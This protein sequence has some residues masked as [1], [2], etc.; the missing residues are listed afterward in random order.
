MATYKGIKG[1][2]VQSL[3]TDPVTAGTSWSSGGNLNMARA[4]IGN[5][6]TQTAA[7]GFGGYAG[8]PA[9]GTSGSTVNTEAYDG[10]SWTE[11]NN[12]N[13][14]K[15]H[16]VAFGLQTAAIFAGGYQD[17]N[18]PPYARTV[19]TETE[20][21]NGTS[22][23]EVNN[24]PKTLYRTAAFGTS[25]AG[26]TAAGATGHPASDQSESYSWDG[27][28]WTDGPNVN[29]PRS[30]QM[31]L[32]TST[33]GM[34]VG[35]YIQSPAS[36]VGNTEI[37]NGSAWTEVNDL[38]TA[39]REGG[40]STI[41]ST[42][43]GIVF[44]GS[45][46]LITGK[47]EVYN[48]TSWS[49]TADLATARV[50]SP[51][52]SG[53][54]SLALC[55]GGYAGGELTATEEFS[56]STVADTNKNLGQVYYNTTTNLLKLTATVYGTG[57]WASGGNLIT[58]TS[59]MAAFGTQ[60][61]ALSVG[62]YL[63]PPGATGKNEEYNGTSWTEKADINTARYGLRGGGTTTSAIVAG[64]PA[65]ND[66]LVES[67]NGS[68]WTE[69]T[70]MA[71]GK[72][73]GASAGISTAFLMFGGVPPGTGDVNTFYWNGSSWAE[74]GDM[75]QAKRN[76]AGFGTYTSAIAAGGETPSVTANTESYNGT[77]WTEVNNMN[78]A[79]RALAGSG[80]QTAGLVYGGTTGSDSTTTESWNGT[81]WTEVA[82]LATGRLALGGAGTSNTQGFAIG[83]EDPVQAG[84][85]EFTVP[86]S[87][88]NVTVAS[89]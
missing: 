54:G 81:S 45:T 21:W 85:E 32:G 28:N 68:S 3:A 37:W 27:T 2:T 58:A 69:T 44:A 57:A 67:W 20:S 65:P 64:G 76:L 13:Q 7:L 29:T 77:T 40:A 18:A 39:R 49:E 55:F 6:G 24:L 9:G 53:V 22:W 36:V 52:G 4:E 15:G 34:I 11:V 70:E 75:N 63:G 19:Y 83:G 82:D 16:G 48:G 47:T 86:E 79:R 46:P 61:A 87:I 35:G 41:G 14:A 31:G 30:Y 60:T 71:S 12:M 72:A 42:S 56:V 59:G 38:N 51:G 89:S 73:N 17:L 80:S 62:G 78:T 88:S 23:T 5:A 25:T 1:F 74:G 84:T 33:A 10:T 43:E 66:N 50:S 26:I 8:P